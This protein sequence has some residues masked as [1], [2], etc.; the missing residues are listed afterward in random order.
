M[1]LTKGLAGKAIER[2]VED[3][4][5][6]VDETQAAG[7]ADVAKLTKVQAARWHYTVQE[8][9]EIL[10]HTKVPS[11]DLVVTARSGRMDVKGP[12]WLLEWGGGDWSLFLGTRYRG[13]P[14]LECKYWSPRTQPASYMR[15]VFVEDEATPW[16]VWGPR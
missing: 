2:D 13:Q 4:W 8:A 6:L 9:L 1:P 15:R 5:V 14:S 7:P 3:F 16:W 11:D 12:A 10:H